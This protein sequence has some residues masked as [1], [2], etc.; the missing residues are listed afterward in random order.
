MTR[1]TRIIWL[2]TAA[3]LGVLALLALFLQPAR[4]YATEPSATTAIVAVHG[5]GWYTGTPAKIQAVCDQV[6]EPLG[7]PCFTPTYTLSGVA[8]FNR[9][10]AELAT[11]VAD[12]RVQGFNR[13]I[14]IGASAGGNLVGWLAAKG[15]LDA[16]VTISAPTD[17]VR[18]PDW[19]RDQCSCWVVDQFVPSLLKKEHASPALIGVDVPILIVH[20]ADD[21]LV[22]RRQAGRLAEVSPLSTL[23]ILEDSGHGSAIGDSAPAIRNYVSAL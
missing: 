13:I 19:Y 2:T 3:L 18:I 21:T 15:H 7:I 17:L 4:A 16:A 9:A 10:N 22:P 5:G 20:A 6:A 12:L 14:G 23:L 1:R 11:Y 8:P